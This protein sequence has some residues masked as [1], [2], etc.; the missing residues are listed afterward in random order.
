MGAA[1]AVAGEYTGILTTGTKKVV[2]DCSL[3]MFIYENEGLLFPANTCTLVCERADPAQVHTCASTGLVWRKNHCSFHREG[4]EKALFHMVWRW[5]WCISE[6]GQHNVSP[7]KVLWTV[8]KNPKSLGFYFFLDQTEVYMWMLRKRESLLKQDD[9]IT[10][11]SY[12]GISLAEY[13]CYQ[14]PQ[15]LQ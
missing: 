10:D 6:A 11:F 1:Q 9:K 3:L 13:K 12:W 7:A 5:H 2:F 15:E 14:I 4:C 8:D